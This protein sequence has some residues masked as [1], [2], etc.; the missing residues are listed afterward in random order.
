MIK[1]MI[2]VLTVVVMML[3]VAMPAMANHSPSAPD[4]DWYRDNYVYRTFGVDM[5]GYWCDWPGYG[6][7]LHALWADGE[8][9]WADWL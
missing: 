2:L 5:W 8:Y 4:C 1:R 6:W 9:L 3:T 7:Y